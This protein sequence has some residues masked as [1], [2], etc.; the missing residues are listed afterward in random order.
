[1]GQHAK[2]RLG[3]RRGRTGAGAVKGEE[4]VGNGR[5]NLVA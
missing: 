2:K 3:G 4:E 1:M 5:G